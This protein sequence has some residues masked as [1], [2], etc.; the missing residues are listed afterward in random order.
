MGGWGG[1]PLGRGRC[2]R[3]QGVGAAAAGDGHGT[4]EAVEDPGL[5]DGERVVAGTP[6]TVTGVAAA[7]AVTL[8]VPLPAHAQ[9]GQALEAGIVDHAAED[10]AVGGEPDWRTTARS[11]TV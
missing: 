8:N 9:Q 3:G 2:R 11:L 5:A 4:L 7:V 1:S 10:A 6:A